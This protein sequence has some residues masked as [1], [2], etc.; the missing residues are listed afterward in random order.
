MRDEI[1]TE[2]R[3]LWDAT[4]DGFLDSHE[5]KKKGTKMPDVH[6]ENASKLMN[7]TL[8]RP[9]VRHT[10][11]TDLDL[12]LAEATVGRVTRMGKEVDKTANNKGSSVFKYIKKR[13][14]TPFTDASRKKAAF[15]I[16]LDQASRSKKLKPVDISPTPEKHL[17]GLRERKWRDSSAVF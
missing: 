15:D 12:S 5:F 10:D 16:I 9:R 7:M 3:E 17:G 6:V 13:V 8:H 1:S 11:I 14:P 4:V 2:T